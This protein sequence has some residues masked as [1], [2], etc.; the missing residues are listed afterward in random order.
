MLL[1]KQHLAT[2]GGSTRSQIST[3]PSGYQNSPRAPPP[4]SSPSPR[5]RPSLPAPPAIPTPLRTAAPSPS[6]RL[7]PSTGESGDRS[8]RPRRPAVLPR[9]Y[10]SS[11][12]PLPRVSPPPSLTTPPCRNPPPPRASPP[13]LWIRFT[14]DDVSMTSSFSE[15]FV[16]LFLSKCYHKCRFYCGFGSPPLL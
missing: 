3:T 5:L 4:P 9:P 1:Y 6:Q 10:Q 11:A 2:G 13:L 16:S 12:E 7:R 14:I 15:A 8:C